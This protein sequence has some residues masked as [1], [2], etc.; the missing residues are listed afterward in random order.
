[1][2]PLRANLTGSGQRPNPVGPWTEGV[3]RRKRSSI[4]TGVF[5]RLCRDAEKRFRKNRIF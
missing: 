4:E 2:L 5:K 3:F 1:M